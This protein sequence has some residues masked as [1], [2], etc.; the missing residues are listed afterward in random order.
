MPPKTRHEH[1]TVE[2]W[3]V[4]AFEGSL[5]FQP[6][7]LLL[8]NTYK[9]V[10]VIS[11]Q[12]NLVY[13]VWC[14]NEHEL[15][16]L[17]VSFSLQI[18]FDG[19]TT[20]GKPV[21]LCNCRPFTLRRIASFFALC[22]LTDILLLRQTDPYQIHSLL[23]PDEASHAPSHLLGVPTQK[24]VKRLDSLLFVLK[25][26]KGQ[27]CVRPWQAHHPKGNV[28][29]LRDAL[30]HRFDGFYASQARVGY[31]DC[32]LGYIPEAEGAQLEQEDMYTAMGRHGTNGSEGR[33]Q[34]EE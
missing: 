4:A 20:Y 7:R 8:D 31:G 5:A 23:H 16:G 12:Y 3:G 28:L 13:Q 21:V 29:T 2:L 6:D 14:T 34:E 25:S 10:R 32:E 1:V 24:V 30:S 18:Y 22:I 9:T 27:S 19:L 33:R 11:N 26:C 17:T 15:Y